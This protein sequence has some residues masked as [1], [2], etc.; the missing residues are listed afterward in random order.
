MDT[1]NSNV[2]PV[3]YFFTFL[4][5]KKFAELTFFVNK[6]IKQLVSMFKL[7]FFTTNQGLPSPKCI[8]CKFI[9]CKR[10]HESVFFSFPIFGLSMW[11]KV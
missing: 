5:T 4:K 7:I 8:W 1:A 9:K 10:S 3:L 2:F 11:A 6:Q